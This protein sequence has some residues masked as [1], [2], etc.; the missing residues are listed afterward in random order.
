MSVTLFMLNEDI[1]DMS[2]KTIT[3][4]KTPITLRRQ[5]KISTL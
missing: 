3:Y 1:Y 4:N 2:S 5:K